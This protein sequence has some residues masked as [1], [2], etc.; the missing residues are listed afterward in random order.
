MIDIFFKVKPGEIIS[1]E[2]FVEFCSLPPSVQFAWW[3]R[4][5]HY[6]SMWSSDWTLPKMRQVK[7]KYVKNYHKCS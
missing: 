2:L 6:V 7:K 5:T 4:V 3:A 1:S